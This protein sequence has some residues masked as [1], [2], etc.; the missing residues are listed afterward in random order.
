MKIDAVQYNLKVKRLLDKFLAT[1]IDI[2][3]KKSLIRF[4][5][6]NAG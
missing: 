5:Q 1:K 2:V 3:W 6:D 4:W